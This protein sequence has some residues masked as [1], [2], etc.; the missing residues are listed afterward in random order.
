M[1]MFTNCIF[2]ISGIKMKNRIVMAP[3][4]TW[5]GNEDGSVSDAEIAYYQRRAKGVGAIITACAYVMPQGKAFSG[6]IGVHDDSMLPGLARLASAIHQKGALAILQI[7]H[8]GRM[9]P[10]EVLADH[11]AV[12]PS[13]IAAEREG[14]SI[15]R[16]MTDTEIHETISAF[17]KATLRAI[18][19]GFDGVEI[20]GANTYLIQQFF[21]PHSNRRNDQWGGDVLRRMNFPLNIVRTVNDMVRTFAKRPFLVGYR[22]S[23]EEI[24]NPGITID[25]TLE[26][27]NAL[28]KEKLDYMH[29]ST[30]NF[31][32]GSMRD[33]AA[34]KSRTEII[35]QQIGQRIPIIGV[36]SVHTLDDA[37]RIFNIGIP[38]VALGRELLMEPDWVQK[39][40]NEQ[41]ETIRTQLDLNAQKELAIPDPLWHQLISRKGWIPTKE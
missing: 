29:V 16:Q 40:Q 14:A 22:I 11:Q 15:P 32:D 4:T 1:D 34:R 2:P 30:M 33:K 21:S 6:Q 10:P 39:V 27:I 7:H 25:D 18:L 37:E 38:I 13:A 12:S 8:G 19:A 35:Y 9:S 23:P 28:Q 5:S 3:M 36:G 17:G 41:T 31:W 26:L 24:E 20:H